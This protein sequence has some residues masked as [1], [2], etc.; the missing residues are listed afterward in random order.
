MKSAKC[1][2]FF[3]W[4]AWAIV[5]TGRANQ[6]MD[7]LFAEADELWAAGQ[8]QS[9]ARICEQIE[10]KEKSFAASFNVALGYFRDGQNERSL[11]KIEEIQSAYS[12]NS[13]QRAKLDRLRS[14]VSGYI[15]YIERVRT[16]YQGKATLSERERNALSAA[17]GRTSSC[18]PE[19]PGDQAD[20]V[21]REV[22]REALIGAGYHVPVQNS[23]IEPEPR[24]LTTR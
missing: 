7:N 18:F 8:Y 24:A 10:A 5:S 14:E 19:V 21:W 23:G 1:H 3:F 22:N 15:T 16:K 9:Y 6:E 13:S 4:F 2:L 12:L 17:C 11:R 20:D